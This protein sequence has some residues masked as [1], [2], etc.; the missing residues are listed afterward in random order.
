[1]GGIPEIH[2]TKCETKGSC[3]D[4][5]GAPHIAITDDGYINVFAGGHGGCDRPINGTIWGENPRGQG[6]KFRK[7]FPNDPSHIGRQRHARSLEPEDIFQW[8][9]MTEVSGL[10]PHASYGHNVISEGDIYVIVRAGTY[11]IKMNIL[12]LSHWSGLI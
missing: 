10:K 1:M 7:P 12:K 4:N 6:C 5:H 3:T 2:P 11:K 9:I 8:Q